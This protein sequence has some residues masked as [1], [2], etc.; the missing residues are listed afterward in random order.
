[1]NGLVAIISLVGI[2][3]IMGMAFYGQWQTM[4]LVREA[5]GAFPI[6]AAVKF[7]IAYQTKND[8]TEGV[9]DD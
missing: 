6:S 9:A 8:S 5:S 4:K 2:L 7:A 1:M 3:V